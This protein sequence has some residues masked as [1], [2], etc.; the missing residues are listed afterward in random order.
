MKI[1][2]LLIESIYEIEKIKSF[3]KDNGN[4][5]ISA[6]PGMGKS[7]ATDSLKKSGYKVSDSD[8]SN[9]SKDKFPQNYI[10]HIKKIK[11]KKDIVFISSHKEVRDSL[12]DN[13]IEYIIIYPYQSDK[14]DMM[15]RYKG[16]GNDEKF[17]K[18]MDENYNNFIKEIEKEDFPV[19]IK[20]HSNK[21]LKDLLDKAL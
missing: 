5:I 17:I 11:N 14:E 18:F 21:Y 6:F 9:F 16:R 13:N 20:I 1:N 19:K 7:F 3:K 2:Q 4:I 8:S 10:D 12:K 15:E